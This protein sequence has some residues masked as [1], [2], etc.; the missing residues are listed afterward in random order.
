MKKI[1]LASFALAAFFGS[2]KK[3][4]ETTTPPTTTTTDSVVTVSGDISANTTWSASKKYVLQ[5]FVYV[6]S[7]VTLTIEAGTVIRGD[8]ATK[9]TLVI[10][11]G[12]KINAVGTADKPIIFTSNLSAGARNQ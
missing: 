4:T 9:G 6:K 3:K 10:S 11:R 5:G 7:G 2:C 12:G 1:F 8:K